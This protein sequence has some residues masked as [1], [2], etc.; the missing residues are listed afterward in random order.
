MPHEITIPGYAEAIA[1]ERVWRGLAFLPHETKICGIPIQE[2]TPIHWERFRYAENPFIVGGEVRWIHI[3]HALWML[4]PS[5]SGDSGEMERFQKSCA[6]IKLEEARKGLDDY[7]ERTFLDACQGKIAI[8]YY[9]A[10]AGLVHSMSESPFH[11]AM[12]KTLET[13]LIISFQLIKARDRAAGLIVVNA[14]SDK[15]RGDWLDEANKK[16]QGALEK[17]KKKGGKKRGKG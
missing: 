3:I 15:V 2:M 16:T 17:R 7:F 13:P 5:F 1:Q 10:A 12:E 11:W 14:L 9:S 4:S 8:P 6:G